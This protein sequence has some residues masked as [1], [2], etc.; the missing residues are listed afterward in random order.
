[1]AKPA[2]IALGAVLLAA[3]GALAGYG[4]TRK[5]TGGL[6]SA[7]SEAMGSSIAQ[8]DGD[9]KTAR[10][11]VKERART[12]ATIPVTETAIGTNPTTA[13]EMLIVGGELAFKPQQGEVIE[14]GQ[15]AKAPG[16]KPTSTIFRS[17]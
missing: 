2:L 12:I 6:S 8:L 4:V 14:V 16:S 10:G 7:Q 15:T 3:G 17:T 13:E 11:I 1:M 5:A 9:V